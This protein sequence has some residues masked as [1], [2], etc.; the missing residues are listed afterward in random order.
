MKKKNKWNRFSGHLRNLYF[1]AFFMA[2]LVKKLFKWLVKRF[3]NTIITRTWTLIV[4]ILILTF[5]C[6]VPPLI[7]LEGFAFLHHFGF[8]SHFD[9]RFLS[10]IFMRFK[11]V[12]S[13]F[14]K[15]VNIPAQSSFGDDAEHSNLVLRF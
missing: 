1:P 5:F 9:P 3:I 8:F 11:D 10:D 15:K 7:T 6:S 13:F 12:L 14:L 2:K 4:P